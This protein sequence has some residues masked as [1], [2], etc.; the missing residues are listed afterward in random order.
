MKTDKTDEW[1][2][3]HAGS[4][5]ARSPASPEKVLDAVADAC[6]SNKG[7]IGVYS[8]PKEKRFPFYDEARAILRTLEIR[9]YEVVEK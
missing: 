4:A 2:W 6:A 1:D 3:K 9:G 5:A 8:M 7:W